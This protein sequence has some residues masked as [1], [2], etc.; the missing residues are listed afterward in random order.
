MHVL[1]FGPCPGGRYSYGKVAKY[2]GAGLA[3]RGFKVSYACN[4]ERYEISLGGGKKADVYPSATLQVGNVINAST[5][6][7]YA[8]KLRPD[9]ILV[10]GG[11]WDPG[12]K[13]ELMGFASARLSSQELRKIRLVGH[14]TFDWF[15]APE[16]SVKQP[17]LYVHVAAM[18][19]EAERRYAA[20]PRD[21]FVKVPHG[22]NREIFNPD[23]RP[24]P[25]QL[26]FRPDI[27]VGS[28]MKNHGRKNWAAAAFVAAALNVWGFK[29]AFLP[30]TTYAT[31]TQNWWSLDDVIK[32]AA[33]FFPSAFGNST[34][35]AYLPTTP[36]G[37]PQLQQV[38][39][40]VLRPATS[41]ELAHGYDEDEQ[42]RIMKV[43]DIHVLPTRGEGFSL[44]VL[45]SLA[46]GIPN[47]VTDTEVLRELYWRYRSVVFVRPATYFVW[48]S[49][50]TFFYEVDMDELAHR[51]IDVAEHLEEYKE[52]AARDAE[53][54]A[55][56]Y[57]WERAVE[58]MER[59]LD[60]SMK[61]DTTMYEDSVDVLSGGGRRWQLP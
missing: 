36:G 9:F 52:R 34:L 21:R 44:A 1:V 2:L 5:L 24:E 39:L 28:V 14:F 58:A 47:I 57:T 59:A 32:G 8:P 50:G 7:Y 49:E 18:P 38:D 51:A 31:G 27:V 35:F 12:I 11:P 42:A 53:R 19:T 33:Q 16:D 43:M 30:F 25:I 17:F 37:P 4:S 54:A 26:P 41:V 40:P 60:L 46:L 45:E 10:I 56:E 22:V 20:I 13:F 3:A 48:P 15:A 23:V 6:T 61:F 55:R 29:T